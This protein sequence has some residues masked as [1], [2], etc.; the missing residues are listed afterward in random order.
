MLLADIARLLLDILGSLLVGLLLLR[1]WMTAIR[2]P[3]RNP[4][5]LFARS[6]TDWLVGP[7]SR[8]VPSGSRIEWS[9]MV[10]ALLVAVLVL[11]LK[12][13]L[14]SAP[15]HWD[16][17]LIGALAQLIYWALSLVIWVTLIYVLVSWINPHAPVAPAL[18]TLL[19]PLLGPI[20]RVL[21]A[22]GGI[23]LS[24]M[25][26]LILVYIAQ[27]VIGRSGLFPGLL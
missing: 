24:P 10:A 7:I 22:V 13:A 15:I 9:A 21:P 20:Q 6:L 8:L 23:D 11:A 5:A 19:R 12:V 26:L 18:A 1:A 3:T 16:W 25:V 27:I 4:L 2:M 14:R 17:I